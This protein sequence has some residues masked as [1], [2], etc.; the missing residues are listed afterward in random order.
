MQAA[1]KKPKQPLDHEPE[2]VAYALDNSGLTMTQLA[3]MCGVSLSL[4]SEIIAGTRNATPVMIGKLASALNCPR[5][6]LER[7]RE[8][9]TAPAGDVDLPGVQGAERSGAVGH[10]L[11]ERGRPPQAPAAAT[12]QEVR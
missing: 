7:K 9:Q 3:E 5:V 10:D 6:V 4:I 8:P 2:A 12:S 1:R 11:P